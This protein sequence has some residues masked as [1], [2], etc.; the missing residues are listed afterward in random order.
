MGGATHR[1]RNHQGHP[2]IGDSSL[3]GL[4]AAQED[5]GCLLFKLFGRSQES[6]ETVPQQFLLFILGKG[7]AW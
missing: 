3:L 2:S 7:G 6:I 1:S 4:Q 5:R